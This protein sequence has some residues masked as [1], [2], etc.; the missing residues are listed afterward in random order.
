MRASFAGSCMQL[1][2]RAATAVQVQA[3]VCKA[4]Y[5]SMHMFASLDTNHIPG[6]T[7]H[8]YTIGSCMHTCK[9]LLLQVAYR[10]IACNRH[11]SSSKCMQGTWNILYVYCS[12]VCVMF[13]IVFVLVFFSNIIYLRVR[14]LFGK[15]PRTSTREARSDTLIEV[16]AREFIIFAY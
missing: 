12:Y 9:L 11:A 3:S 4:Q 15:T 10:Q 14:A 8:V 7:Y 6:M 13:V 1:T 5:G 2:A 16:R